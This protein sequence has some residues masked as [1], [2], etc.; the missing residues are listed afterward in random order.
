MEG[1]LL[2]ILLLAPLLTFTIEPSFASAIVDYSPAGF[3][4]LASTTA[5]VTNASSNVFTTP[6]GATFSNLYTHAPSEYGGANGGS[7]AVVGS[8]TGSADIWSSTLTFD[9]PVSHFGFWWSAADPG[10]QL[11]LYSGNQIILSMND[12]TLINALGSCTT[13]NNPYCGNPNNGQDKKELFVYVNIYDPDITSAKFSQTQWG[14]FEFDRLLYDTDPPTSTPEPTT[15]ALFGIGLVG[16]G[17]ARKLRI[18]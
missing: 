3:Q 1:I 10:N 13:G 17:L 2:R 5:A 16:A 6:G 12:Q 15:W 8:P 4:G 14:G 11:T 7:Y 9:S 18:C